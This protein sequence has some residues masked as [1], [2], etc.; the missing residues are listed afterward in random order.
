MPEIDIHLSGNLELIDTQTLIFNVTEGEYLG[1]K[2]E[3]SAIQELFNLGYL[4]FDFKK[5]LD[6]STIKSIKINEDSILLNVNPVLF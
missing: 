4:K 1:L 5:L 3:K 6:K 2:L